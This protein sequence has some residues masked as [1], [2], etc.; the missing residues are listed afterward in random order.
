MNSRDK[1]LNAIKETDTPPTGTPSAKMY[2]TLF[3]DPVL[4][5]KTSLEAAGGEAV[6]VVGDLSEAITEAFDEMT[7]VVDTREYPL[8]LPEK[9]E[10]ID[11]AIIKGKFG[12]AENGAVWIN[13]EERYPRSLL[14]LAKNLAIIL[15]K[16]TIVTTMQEAYGQ[17]DFKDI[18]YALF[19][20]GPSKTAD[21]EQALV[22]GAHGAIGL[23]V[24]LI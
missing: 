5:F 21:I 22:I 15:S 10:D 12:V 8:S 2:T 23:K 19:L 18:S 1:I 7:I 3:D 20:S 9:L 16:D 6:E 17:I 14:T 13:P 24:F 4:A 11:L